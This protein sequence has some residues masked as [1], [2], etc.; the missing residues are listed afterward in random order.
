MRAGAALALVA[1]CAHRPTGPAPVVESLD[2][3][4]AHAVSASAIKKKIL[5]AATG[6]WPWSDDK[7]FDLLVWEAD[8]ARITRVYEAHGHY[9]AK[10]VETQVLPRPGNRVALVV[11]IDEGRP[12]HIAAIEITGMEELP[13]KHRRRALRELPLEKDELF[14]EADWAEAKA[15]IVK[16][17][18]D[19]GY[20]A[21]T[22][23][24]QAQVDIGTNQARLHLTVHPGPRYRF[25]AITVNLP[26]GGRVDPKLVREQI[27]LELGQGNAWFSDEAIAEAQRRVFAMGVFSTARVVAGRPDPQSLRVPVTV[28]AREAPY[29]TV[30]LGGGAGLDQVRQDAHLLAEWTNRDFLGGLRRLTA[31]AVAGWAFVPDIY[32]VAQKS[33][34]QITRDGP[35]YRASLDFEQ[36]RFI[37]RPSLYLTSLVESERTIEQAYD[38]IG[39][40]GQLGIRYRPLASLTIAPAYN[41]QGWQLNGPRA[42]GA[43]TAP[44]ALGCKSDPCF[45][46]LSYVEE[47]ATWD[48]R[49]SPLEPRRGHYVSLSLQQG[50]GPLRGD[51]DYFRI[52][53]EARGYVTL[54]GEQP[55][56]FAGRLS[57]GTLI[58]TS[59]V[60][61]D[62][63]V[64]TRFYSGG[65]NSMRGYGIRRLSPLLLIP[66]PRG[67]GGPMVTVPIGGNG[68]VEG[69]FEVRTPLTESLM[70]AGFLDFGHVTQGSLPVPALRDFQWAAGFGF[71]YL[72]PIGPIRLD[73]GF[74]LPVGRPPPLFDLDGR[75]ITY[76]MLADGSAEPGR[77]GGSHVN[78]SCFGIG[79]SSGGVW[80]KDGLC[81]FH[82]S[83]GESF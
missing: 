52:V 10:V 80:V 51:F 2:L 15:G 36:P 58:T 4:G 57:V 27:D 69:S 71:R 48:R 17:L 25:G 14:A 6:R 49:D 20:A 34:T 41:V 72:T 46:L 16:W 55:V 44:L 22:V 54:G 59:G 50:G 37:S 35:I 53:P 79:G 12:M 81:A 33:S 1:A 73:L 70:V 3:E 28:D 30:R 24:G 74:R 63:A 68:V 64:V 7:T 62:S 13:E 76:R 60:P 65:G 66:G 21:A 42:A 5:T 75:E 38:A 23:E 78:R 11:R 61:E 43:R 40:R 29:H 32:T 39:G 9:G 82:I 83:I 56:T 8:L 47:I 77:E 45:V 18:R 31:R 19:Q 26:P 67:E